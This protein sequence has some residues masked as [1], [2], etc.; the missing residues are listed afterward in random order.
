MFTISNL[1]KIKTTNKA[2]KY[3]SLQSKLDEI[4][5]EQKS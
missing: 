1:K 2:K 4:K 5:S 3:A